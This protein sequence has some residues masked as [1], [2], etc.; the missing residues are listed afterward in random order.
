[1]NVKPE[2]NAVTQLPH[3]NVS[4]PPQTSLYRCLFQ[5]KSRSLH[6]AISSDVKEE[7]GPAHM[8]FPKYEPVNV[9]YEAVEEQHSVSC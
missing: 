7:A 6:I 9:D 2:T 1:M 3:D 4:V 8:N 5:R